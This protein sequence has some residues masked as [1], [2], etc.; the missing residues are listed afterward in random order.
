M[1]DV[2]LAPDQVIN[3]LVWLCFYIVTNITIIFI[4]VIMIISSSFLSS[5]TKMSPA[6]RDHNENKAFCL[7]SVIPAICS[8]WF[9]NFVAKINF[10]F[11][12]KY[13]CYCFFLNLIFGY[14]LVILHYFFFVHGKIKLTHIL[15]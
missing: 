2:I 6:L 9:A 10:N 12:F 5:L 1:G 14:K 7:F 15:L 4:V 3:S 13:N 11:F 8:L